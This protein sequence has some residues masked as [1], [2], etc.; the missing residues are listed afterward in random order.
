[1]T[2]RPLVAAL[3]WSMFVAML[4]SMPA[5]PARAHT[6]SIA[7]LDIAIPQGGGP[8]E[9]E[10]DLS[11]R[12]LALTLPIDANRDERVTW[13]E[14]S[15]ARGQIESLVLSNLT[16]SNG[17]RDCELTP[18]G[19]ATRQY[20]DGTYAT[21]SMAASC[22]AGDRL[23]VS[24]TA[25]MDRD[26]QHRALVTIR[27]GDQVAAGIARAGATRVEAAISG[28]EFGRAGNAFLD[29][30]REGIHHILIG[31][32]HIAFL[33]SL[34]LPAAL[35][36]ID[37]RWKPTPTFRVGFV[38][39]LGIASAF[40]VAHSITLSLAALRWVTPATRWVE[41]AI[42]ASV[43]LAALNNVWPMVTR[44][45]WVVG[46]AFGLVHGFGF[47]GVLSELGL[48][49]GARLQALVGFNLGVEIGQ[50]AII[51]V[52]LPVLFALRRKRWYAAVAM[53]IASLA[54]AA[55]AGYWMWQRLTG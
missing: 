4:L 5:L 13:G 55:L 18:T 48:P 36:R 52:L 15:A 30:L 43:L 33:I 35:L 23:Q 10:L 25:L 46:F 22:P 3:L 14:L 49:D 39:V 31:Y 45:L 19:L 51:C 27:R 41:A 29:F 37:G 32:D 53:P 47:A 40:T 24:Y 38:H 42:A 7:H 20:D 21:L 34:L 50:I 12:D 2:S 9:L 11:I 6:V 17:N 16:L 44:R 54:I 28:G 1:M 8:A 26:P